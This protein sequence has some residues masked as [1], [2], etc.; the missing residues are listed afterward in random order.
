MRGAPGGGAG[1]AA[2]SSFPFALNGRASSR[3]KA[4]GIMYS[5]NVLARCARSEAVGRSLA[6]A[7]I[8]E[9]A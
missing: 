6:A 8:G 9:L 5:G 4:A 2:R 7:A 3:T 1:S